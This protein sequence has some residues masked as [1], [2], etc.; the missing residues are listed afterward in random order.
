MRIIRDINTLMSGSSKWPGRS[1][2]PLPRDS[3][4]MAMTGMRLGETLA[5][6]RRHLD[7]ANQQ[8]LLSESIKGNRY[9][10]PKGGTRRLT[11][12]EQGL[13][14]KLEAN[15]RELRK[16]ALAWERRLVTSSPASP[17]ARCSGPRSGLV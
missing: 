1:C 16:V 3:G 13:V 10:P 6:Q 12:L 2:A 8:Y 5:M 4:D 17:S 14:A 7:I 15:V 9:G 11:G